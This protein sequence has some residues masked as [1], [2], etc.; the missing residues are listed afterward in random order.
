MG[1]KVDKEE[2]NLKLEGRI[3]VPSILYTSENI[4][5]ILLYWDLLKHLKLHRSFV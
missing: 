4:S 3:H 1:R 2:R 5:N